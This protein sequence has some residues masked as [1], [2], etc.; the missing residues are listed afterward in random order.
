MGCVD[1][2]TNRER[3]GVCARPRRTVRLENSHAYTRVTGRGSQAS[4]GMGGPDLAQREIS[5][6]GKRQSV[7][8]PAVPRSL[9]SKPLTCFD[10]GSARTETR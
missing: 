9:V 1:A 6:S 3:P 2:E 4:S 7:S 5:S 10:E 8:K